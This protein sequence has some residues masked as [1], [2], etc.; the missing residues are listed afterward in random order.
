MVPQ[1]S[2]AQRDRSAP[3]MM[4]TKKTIIYTLLG[5]PLLIYPVILIANAMSA[6]AFH[7]Q[8]TPLL[9]VVVSGFLWT[10]TLYP[11]SYLLA[12]LPFLRKRPYGYFLPAG[13]LLTAIAFFMLWLYLS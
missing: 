10:S 8:S 9:T 7:G 13:H 4:T 2:M 3:A 6:G 1:L 12:W 11:I 5:L